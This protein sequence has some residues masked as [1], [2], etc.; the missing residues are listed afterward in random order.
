MAPMKRWSALR[1]GLVLFDRLLLT[2]LKSS[3]QLPCP[4]QALR[5]G[6]RQ[7]P[8]PGGR[9]EFKAFVPARRRP[10]GPFRQRHRDGDAPDPHRPA[11]T[12]PADR[13]PLALEDIIVLDVRPPCLCVDRD[14]GRHLPPPPRRRAAN[15]GGW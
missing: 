14:L 9:E 1:L 11:K 5:A 13:M 10:F 2:S 8:A 6:L 15:P 12:D 4:L 3:L 7:Q